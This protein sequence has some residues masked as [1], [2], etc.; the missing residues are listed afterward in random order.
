VGKA[1]Y[2]FASE[3]DFGLDLILAGLD[4]LRASP[5]R[6]DPIGTA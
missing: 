5:D 4:S 3:F 1:G 6:A 2:D